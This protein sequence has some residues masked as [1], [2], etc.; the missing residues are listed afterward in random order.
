[1]FEL[2]GTRRKVAVRGTTSEQTSLPIAMHFAGPSFRPRFTVTVGAV[3][4]S[5]VN[6]DDLQEFHVRQS[7]Y[8]EITALGDVATRYPTLRSLYL[9]QV[10]GTVIAV[11]A[12]YGIQRGRNGTAMSCTA[13]VD[14]SPV[15]VSGCRFHLSFV[16]A[17]LVDAGDLARLEH[18]L[19]QEPLLKD[20]VRVIALP[21]KLDER[22]P[23]AVQPDLLSGVALGSGVEPHTFTLGAAVVDDELPAVSKMNL[24]MSQLAAPTPT[25]QGQFAIELDDAFEGRVPV[26]FVIDLHETAGSDDV[27]I[28]VSDGRTSVSNLSPFALRVRRW[29]ATT[30][31]GPTSGEVDVPLAAAA[32]VPIEVPAGAKASAVWCDLDLPPVLPAGE[33]RRYL[34]IH[35]EDVQRVHHAV[36]FNAAGQIGVDIRLVSV[37]L[38][39]VEAPDVALPTLVLTADHPIEKTAVEIPVGFAL[40][41]LTTTVALTVRP[42]DGSPDIL[43]VLTHDFATSP[44][45][46]LTSAD[47]VRQ[48]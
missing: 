47:F 39:L 15:A 31:E 48:P 42:A 20:R 44:I 32:S 11:P 41:G 21:S 45:L 36:G 43:R 33:L 19:R 37:E 40:G 2:V 18:D 22:A 13:L 7:E 27:A 29:S 9:G 28:V 12:L 34:S 46:T 1:L 24:V 3:Q 14:T 38:A 16:L 4:R 23:A 6:A 8:I 10:S 30:A 5:I 35:A 26:G 25:V 17:P